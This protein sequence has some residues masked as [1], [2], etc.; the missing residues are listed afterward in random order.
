M[1]EDAGVLNRKQIFASVLKLALQHLPIIPR[2]IDLGCGHCMFMDIAAEC[3]V[4]MWGVDARMDRVP[5][6]WR[7]VVECG[8]I[9]KVTFEDYDLV[10]CL[11]LF[12]HLT[13]CDQLALMEKVAGKTVIV[14]THY[15]RNG[16]ETVMLRAGDEYFHG[17]MYREPGLTTSGFG[18]EES[19]W[20]IEPELVRMFGMRHM[21][22]K[23]LPEHHPGRSFYLLTPCK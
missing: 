4:R 11:G 20:P 5:D 2:A 22:L 21:V 23:Y 17:L 13:L 7:P 16:E 19:F 6:R 10:L 1:T 12:Y 15:C 9:R 8:D 18:N 3:G 14:D